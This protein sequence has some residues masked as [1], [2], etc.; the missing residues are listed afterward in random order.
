M[1][2]GWRR[3]SGGET[4][5]IAH[6]TRFGF[7]VAP[8][9]DPVFASQRKDSR[10]TTRGEGAM[11]TVEPLPGRILVVGCGGFIGSHFLDRVLTSSGSD[12]IGW[13]V[14]AS[15]V[16]HHL[17]C[18]RL[19]FRLADVAS[20]E[21]RHQLREDVSV[22]DWIINLAALCNPSQ[23]NTEPL[24]TLYTNFIHSYPIIELA[25]EFGKPLMHFSTSEVYGR[26][27]SNLVGD[28]AYERPELYLLDA[29]TSPMVLGPIEAQRWTYACAKQ[30][31][32]RM[33]YAY[34]VEKGLQ[35][36]IIRPFNF[37][38]PRMD[39]LPGIEGEGKP[40]V[41][42]CFLSAL[43]RNQPL[44]LV[45]G[46]RAMRT[47]TSIHD[48]ID[49]MVAIMQR[50]DV[51][52]NHF[53]NIGNPTNEVSIREL[54]NL[55]RRAFAKVSGDPTYLMHP[56]VDIPAS[57]FYGAGYEDSDRRMLSIERESALLGWTPT[58]SLELILDETVRYYYDKYGPTLSLD[59]RAL[60]EVA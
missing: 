54:A 6:F 58:R 47:I 11:S 12:V 41:L 22:S 51:A 23:Y 14:S 8:R 5:A 57:E 17:D 34:H 46:G 13:D 32:E 2:R 40:R 36:A 19:A 3:W 18:P 42:A 28:D 27:I 10:T 33:V 9:C 53:Y 48:A 20:A 56:M 7:F 24:R 29:N 25:A 49:A 31:L 44:Y 45:D 59:Q 21:S 30:L 55:V 4:D 60:D 39:Y 1:L 35:F 16:E 52:L 15:K 38:G 50:P 43:I 26:T 37:F